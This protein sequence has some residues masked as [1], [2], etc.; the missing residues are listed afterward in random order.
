MIEVEISNVSDDHE[1][2]DGELGQEQAEQGQA[3]GFQRGAWSLGSHGRVLRG[4]V[5]FCAELKVGPGGG[6]REGFV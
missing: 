4:G 5:G 2:A 6:E 1:T 3:G